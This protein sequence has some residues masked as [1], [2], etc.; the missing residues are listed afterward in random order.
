MFLHSIG[1]TIGALSWKNAPNAAVGQVIK[2]METNRFEFMG[3][4]TDIASFYEGYGYTMIAVFL[5][6]SALL[7]QLS[8]E[9]NRRLM[10]L[11]AALL[12]IFGVLE[13]IYFFPFAAA[14]SLLAGV[15]TA[16]ALFRYQRN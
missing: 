8:I 12:I 9:N 15:C 4:N 16:L 10:R 1:H 11:A 7:W 2:E 3:R 14:L 13:Y 5:F 6:I